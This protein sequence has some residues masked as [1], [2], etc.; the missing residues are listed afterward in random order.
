MCLVG[1]VIDLMRHWEMCR[2]CCILM[3][4]AAI[5]SVPR[6]SSSSLMSV[7]CSDALSHAARSDALSHAA[8]SSR[9][10][11]HVMALSQNSEFRNLEK[12]F[13]CAVATLSSPSATQSCLVITNGAICRRLNRK[14]VVLP[15]DEPHRLRFMIEGYSKQDVPCK[16]NGAKAPVVAGAR[17]REHWGC[18]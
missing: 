17:C 8:D 6:S 10:S 14:D 7:S 16:Q 2:Q 15:V 5:T 1:W 9:Q 11:V 4:Q 3:I 12:P 13:C 18:R